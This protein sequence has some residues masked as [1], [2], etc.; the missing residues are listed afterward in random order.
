MFLIDQQSTVPAIA[1]ALA[2]NGRA[3]VLS[4]SAHYAISG[5]KAVPIDMGAGVDA[6]VRLS[7]PVLPGGLGIPPIRRTRR[8]LALQQ[9][10]AAIAA[11]ASAERSNPL[12]AYPSPRVDSG[13]HTPAYPNT[14]DRILAAYKIWGAFHYFFAYR[15]QMDDD[16]DTDFK[17]FLPRIA[18][19]PDARSYNLAI[20]ELIARVRDS[21]TKLQSKTLDA[22][23]GQAA[24]G[25]RLRLIERKPVVTD[26]FDPVARTAGIRPGD[27]VLA[28]DGERIAERA[29]REARYVP[30][31]TRQSLVYLV[32]QRVLNGP[33]GSLATLKLESPDGEVREVKL[34]RSKL[35]LPMLRDQRSGESV[36]ILPGNIGYADLNRLV[37]DQ[38]AGMFERLRNTRAAIFDMR[39]QSQGAGAE[40]AARLTERRNV[41]ADVL[42]GALILAPDLPDEEALTRNATYF[43][44]QKLP[45]ADGTR[46]RGKTVMLIDE[47]TAGR[48]E[49][50]ALFF[51]AAN[52]TS[53]I[54]TPSAG[55]IG[56][57]TNFAVP[58]GIVISFS[59]VDVRLANGGQV[60]RLGLQPSIAVAPTIAGMR[61]GR[62]EVLQV[63]VEYLS[64]SR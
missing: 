25:I 47:R 61:A 6:I 2:G 22:Y 63:A 30:A 39:G 49:R 16:W 5:V 15:D 59:A 21:D 36:R 37:P 41:P 29:N 53:F 58:G 55:A 51:K 10:L 42:T 4:D 31:S 8:D 60:Q 48:A 26:V 50:A 28:V 9:A 20:A 3:A 45:N 54:G 40:I 56:N 34:K 1:C 23:F 18:A 57:T 19:A 24:V 12:P 38:V 64:Q 17:E 52:G 13:D 62:D 46:Y 35:F 14:G 27:V 7:E 43:R 44:V 11:P 32:L 33:D